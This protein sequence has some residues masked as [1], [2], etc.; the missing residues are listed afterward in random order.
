[1]DR[2]CVNVPAPPLHSD[3]ESFFARVA[4][5]L[6]RPWLA[7]PRRRRLLFLALAAPGFFTVFATPLHRNLFVALVGFPLFAA[8]VVF[9][10]RTEPLFA[11]SFAV[12]TCPDS[13]LSTGKLKET[14][15]A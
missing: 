1:M 4:A 6:P 8:A 12:T 10:M 15:R 11:K 3:G 7:T 5:R 2:P 9:R 14:P 13:E